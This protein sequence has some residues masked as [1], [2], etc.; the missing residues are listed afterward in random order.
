[1][2]VINTAVNPDNI[3]TLKKQLDKAELKTDC[4]DIDEHCLI[5]LLNYQNTKRDTNTSHK[6]N[7][8]GIGARVKSHKAN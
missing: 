8:M 1:M 7:Y 3:A 5:T 6:S 2:G 4:H